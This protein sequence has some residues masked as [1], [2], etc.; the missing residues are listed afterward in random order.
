MDTK[1][2]DIVVTFDRAGGRVEY[3]FPLW[4]SVVIVAGGMA[5]TALLVVAVQAGWLR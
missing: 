5:L 1:Q 3:R 2:E 4:W